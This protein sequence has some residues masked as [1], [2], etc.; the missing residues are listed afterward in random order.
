MVCYITYMLAKEY[1]YSLEEIVYTTLTKVHKFTYD[2]EEALK[3]FEDKIE[4]NVGPMDNI[5]NVKGKMTEWQLFNNDPEFKS[6]INHIFYPTIIK[7][8][9]LRG[10]LEN[11]LIVKDSWGNILEKGDS[12]ERHHHKDGYYSTIMYF[13]NVAPLQTDIGEFPTHRGL[14]ITIEGFLYHWVNPVKKRRKNLV[15]NWSMQSQKF[16][17]GNR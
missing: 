8:R 5:T 9:P 6:F 3:Y 10:D 11:L 2:D 17:E 14:V 12:V 7:H 4:N 1:S 15:F 16:N 13:D